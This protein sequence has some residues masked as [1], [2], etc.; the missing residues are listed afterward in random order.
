MQWLKPGGLCAVRV[1]IDRKPEAHHNDI[2][3]VPWTL[4]MAD[5][6]AHKWFKN[7]FDVVEMHIE[8]MNT[9]PY[10]KLAVWIWK[11]KQHVGATRN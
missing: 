6:C 2:T 8:T 3:Y 5:Q 10:S 9:P 11:K 4:D 7:Y 1:H